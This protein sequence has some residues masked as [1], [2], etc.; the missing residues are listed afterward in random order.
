MAINN[1]NNSN[2]YNNNYFSVCFSK[3]VLMCN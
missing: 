3:N 1:D 2:N